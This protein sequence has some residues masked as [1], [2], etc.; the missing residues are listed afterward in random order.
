[1]REGGGSQWLALRR[2]RR[3]PPML[4]KHEAA[5][6][7]GPAQGT[8]AMVTPGTAT[9]ASLP[10]QR[11]SLGLTGREQLS[12]TPFPRAQGQVGWN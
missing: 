9:E 11:M 6:L 12:V 1:M 8:V 10:F 3:A 2:P 7:S 4:R 5:V